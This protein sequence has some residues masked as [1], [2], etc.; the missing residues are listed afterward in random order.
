MMNTIPEQCMMY[1]EVF[2][3]VRLEMGL[4]MLIGAALGLLI[5]HFNK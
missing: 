5:A 3:T 4:A 1:T 2:K